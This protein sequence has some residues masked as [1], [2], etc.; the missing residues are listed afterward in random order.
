MRR[1]AVRC[2][3][4]CAV[5]VIGLVLVRAATRNRVEPIAEFSGV[6]DILS[7]G[8]GPFA[9]EDRWLV[10][11][12][13]DRSDL[14]LRLLNRD[15]RVVESFPAPADLAR[16]SASRDL[17]TVVA[18]D[19]Q[20]SFCLIDTRTGARKWH[21]LDQMCTEAFLSP[22]G[23]HL[24]VGEYESGVVH[25]YEVTNLEARRVRNVNIKDQAT[26]LVGPPRLL[27]A[28]D[29]RVVAVAGDGRTTYLH[30]DAHEALLI[31]DWAAGWP[32]GTIPLPD[33]NSRPT[34]VPAPRGDLLAIVANRLVFVDLKANTVRTDRELNDNA[35]AG[36]FDA[37]GERFF[38]GYRA[39]DMLA[40]PFTHRGGQIDAF[41]LAGNRLKTWHSKATRI[42]EFGGR[43]PVAWMVA[44]DGLLQ[45]IRLP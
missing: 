26:R 40:L 37:T 28:R 15:L 17:S 13:S 25:L 4:A 29:F 2:V 20:K 9:H 22:S 44:D 43:G 42:R 34:F 10:L 33:L 31:Y 18:L 32:V 45:T 39:P 21:A 11:D 6:G 19:Y 23:D 30:S 7:T 41:D 38:V 8:L 5:L 36:D 16:L 35:R 27:G 3:M 1:K 24:W 14:R 12:R